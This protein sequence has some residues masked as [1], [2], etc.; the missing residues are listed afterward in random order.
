MPGRVVPR[1]TAPVLRGGVIAVAVLLLAGCLGVS[2]GKDGADGTPGVDGLSGADGADGSTGTDGADGADGSPGLSY[3]DPDAVS[4]S[5]QLTSR[6]LTFSDVT[7]LVVGA[8]FVVHVTIGE[9][10]QATIRMDDNLTDLVDTTVTGDQLRLGLKPGASVRN[11]TLSAEVTVRDL[12][13]LTA[14]GVSQVTLASELTGPALHLDASGASRITGAVRVE[15]VEASASGAG[16]LALSGHAGHL[17]LHGSGT[18]GLKL[19]DLA[20]RDVDAELSGASCATVAASDTLA[21][22]V[23]GAST[24]RYSGTPRITRQQTSGVSSIEAAGS[25]SGDRCGT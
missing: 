16:T 7:T 12:D 15:R 14:S 22:R 5:G 11:A 6:Q 3:S 9:P 24:L 8:G 23:S 1:L 17:D 18:S 13:R 20:V 25:L 10:E 4:G 21:A 2:V 19:P